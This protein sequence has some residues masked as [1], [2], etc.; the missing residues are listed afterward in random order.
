MTAETPSA[1]PVPSASAPETTWHPT[2]KYIR[3]LAGE[4]IGMP[5]PIEFVMSKEW[6]GRD[7]LGVYQR[8]LIR[9]IYGEQ[10]CGPWPADELAA[11]LESTGRKFL[12]PAGYCEVVVRCGIRAGKDSIFS[13]LV[14]WEMLFGGH[15]L[16]VQPGETP[17]ACLIAQDW[18]QSRSVALKLIK[19]LAKVSRLIKSQIKPG[20]IK[21]DSVTL[22]NGSVIRC[23]PSTEVSLVGYSVAVAA[24]N[25]M[26]RWPSGDQA[27]NSDWE[28]YRIVKGRGMGFVKST[29]KRFIYSS[30][31]G[32]SGLFFELSDPW[33]RQEPDDDRLIWVASTFKM[34]P[35][36]P[37]ARLAKEEASDPL[38][39]RM[40]YMA[41]WGSDDAQFLD[42]AWLARARGTYTVLAFEGADG[43]VWACAIDWSGG[44]RDSVTW[45]IGFREIV[46]T[47]T[48][49]PVERYVIVKTSRHTPKRGEVWD[50]AA[51]ADELKKD[52]DAYRLSKVW[53]DEYAGTLL[54]ELLDKRGIGHDVPH[55][56]VLKPGKGTDLGGWHVG[57]YERGKNYHRT[58]IY[59][60]TI[61]LW[62][63]GLVTVPNDP[64]LIQ[65]LSRLQRSTSGGERV[66]HP[67]GEH[68]DAANSVCSV[69]VQL[70]EADVKPVARSASSSILQQLGTPYS[71]TRWGGSYG[72]L[73]AMARGDHDCRACQHRHEKVNGP[74][75]LVCMTCQAIE[76][77]P[78]LI[79]RAPLPKPS[80]IIA[81]VPVRQR[82]FVP[83]TRTER[84]RDPFATA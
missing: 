20:G 84:E 26:S 57:G 49:D 54:T 19:D 51:L 55:E 47:G 78:S 76:R 56:R 73:E 21:R 17:Y 6:C 59:L 81:G 25:E 7:Y 53:T 35:S 71:S 77:D 39:F 64:V 9:S 75:K 68:D 14:L 38:G 30:P 11:S 66:D 29:P 13:C 4:R 5:G 2:G 8:G 61:S 69:L 62:S 80:R 15:D 46:H 18:Q 31:L 23:W 72:S 45:A 74:C 27:V 50:N 65:E 67:S 70:M 1:T 52:L 28:I 36:I 43:R 42:A 82:R 33:G 79:P 41:E 63:G 12:D 24:L 60:K 37:A 44:K 10:L 22:L 83:R 48:G 3:G 32:P 40:D 16:A 34:N 58:D